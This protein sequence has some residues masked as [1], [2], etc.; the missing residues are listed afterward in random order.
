MKNILIILLLFFVY[1]NILYAGG[2]QKK[3]DYVDVPRNS[4]DLNDMTDGDVTTGKDISV[5]NLNANVVNSVSAYVDGDAV[6]GGVAVVLAGSTTIDTITI[7]GDDGHWSTAGDWYDTFFYI[8]GVGASHVEN[9]YFSITIP[10]TILSIDT[11]T[12]NFWHLGWSMA[13]NNT[14]ETPTF[15][16]DFDR[17]IFYEASDTDGIINETD[18]GIAICN[19]IQEYSVNL[20]KTY[21][22][23]GKHWIRFLGSRSQLTAIASSRSDTPPTFTITYSQTTTFADK[24]YEDTVDQMTDNS[25]LTGDNVSVPTINAET[26]TAK[27]ITIDTNLIVDSAQIGELVVT[28]TIS[29]DTFYGDGSQLTG[30]TADTSNLITK[31][32]TATIITMSFSNDTYLTNSTSIDSCAY[33]DTY[34][35]EDSFSIN[36]DSYELLIDNYYIPDTGTFNNVLVNTDLFGCAVVDLSATEDKYY[37]FGVSRN[38]DTSTLKIKARVR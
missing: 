9:A 14:M 15:V 12:L 21:F 8:G 1:L 37:V 17:I 20:D 23:R 29:A 31:E 10:D 26:V 3:I 27:N 28:G 6:S 38:I 30:V 22:T 24:T 13:D 2:Y 11:I 33:V 19:G 35:G 5:P 16:A 34:V 4:T 32:D 36:S 7:N 25:V 18:L